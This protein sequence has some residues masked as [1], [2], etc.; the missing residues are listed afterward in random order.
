[1][2]YWPVA[3]DFEL[4]RKRADLKSY[5]Q[6]NLRLF[7]IIEPSNEFVLVIHEADEPGR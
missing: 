2:K 1:M 6:L 3:I 5:H 4:A 7:Y